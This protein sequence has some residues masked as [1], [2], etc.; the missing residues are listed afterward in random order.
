[1]SIEEKVKIYKELGQTIEELEEQKKLLGIE[2]LQQMT[3]KSFKTT[4]YLVKKYNRLNIKT[5]LEEARLFD[6]VKTVETVDKEKIK[7]LYQ[8]G[9]AIE[10]VSETQYIQVSPLSTN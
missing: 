8:R 1:M 3:E 5:S 4:D 6:A 2:I 9:E 10:G 7:E